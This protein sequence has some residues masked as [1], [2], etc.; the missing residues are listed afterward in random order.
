M[1]EVN[2]SDSELPGGGNGGDGDGDAGRLARWLQRLAKAGNRLPDPLTFFVLL[3]G[4]VVLASMAFDGTAVEVVQRTGETETKAVESLLSRDGI[5]WMLLHAIDNFI[6]FAPL[7][8]VLV[9]ML[10]IGVAERTGFITVGLRLLIQA[11]PSSLIT[12]TLVFAGVMSSMAADAGYVV[13]VPLGA[14]LFAGLGRH[15]LA[16]LAAAFAGVSGGFSANLL[17]TGLDPMLARLTDQ[18]AHTIDPAYS[19]NAVCNYYFM[20]AST[21]LVTAVG[22]WVT[23]KIVEPMLGEW[24]PE[25]AP[26]ELDMDAA[27]GPGTKEKR[28]F[29]T[30]MGVGVVLAGAMALL[31]AFPEAPLRDAIGPDDPTV[32]MFASFFEAIELLIMVL[33]LLPAIIYGVMVGKIKNDKD[34][35]AMAGKAMG[36]MG[37]YIALAFVA[38]QF[39]AYFNHSNLGVVTAV[40]G[41][42]FLEAMEFTGIPLLLSFLVVSALMNLF[43]GSA[44]AKWAFM[45]PIFVPMMMMMG[46]SPETVQVTYRVGDSVTNIITPLMPYLPIIIVFAQKYDRKAGLGTLIAAMLPY[47]IAFGIAWTLMLVGWMWLGLPLGPGAEMFYEAAAP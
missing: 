38:G 40:R 13:L 7:G 18:A 39:V 28:A 41:A 30:A 22:T 32:N 44:S 3:A 14:V 43:V 20:F 19:V 35:A 31:A 4:T 47:S 15:P 45:A 5:R 10:G 34:V 1:T 36:A 17:I 24:T 26:E 42:E 25:E 16:G 46:L 8:P 9:V 21:F 11:V 37:V 27:A 29:L 23:V 12:A 33:F 2:T 6:N